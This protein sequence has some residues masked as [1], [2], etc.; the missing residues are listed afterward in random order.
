MEY[1]G[2][3]EDIPVSEETMTN[4]RSIFLATEQ[5]TS[6]ADVH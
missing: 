5:E 1:L 6:R 2:N 3:L 4:F